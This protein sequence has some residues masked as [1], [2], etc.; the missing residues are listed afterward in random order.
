MTAFEDDFLDDEHAEE[1]SADV[2]LYPRC[3]RCTAS[4]EHDELL[5]ALIALLECSRG[6]HRF[7]LVIYCPP[8]GKAIGVFDPLSRKEFAHEPNQ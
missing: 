1:T 5:D 8:C 6:S 4:I 3:F 2:A 7:G